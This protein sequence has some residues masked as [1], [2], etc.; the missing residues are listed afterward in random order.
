MPTQKVVTVNEQD[1]LELDLTLGQVIQV[2]SGTVNAVSGTTLIPFDNT[3]PLITE[4]F[5][6]LTL[7]V[8]PK[9]TDSKQYI[10]LNLNVD[11]STNN[12]TI[13]ATVWVNTSLIYTHSVN[14]A[15]AGRPLSLPIHTWF[16]SLDLTAK[17]VQVRVGANGS[18]TTYVGASAGVNLGGNRNTDY[19]LMEVLNV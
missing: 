3:T 19:S 2:V 5:Q 16:D 12:R 15:T 6:L 7:S 8:T 11:H 4:G 17:T 10:T 13:T 1:L 9:A 14:I 18:G